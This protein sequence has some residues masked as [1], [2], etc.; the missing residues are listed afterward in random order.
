MVGLHRIIKTLCVVFITLSVGCT[1][2]GEEELSTAPNCRVPQYISASFEA[3]IVKTNVANDKQIL[4]SEGDEIAYFPLSNTNLRY[5]LQSSEGGSN[6]TFELASDASL[7]GEK[8]NNSYAVYPYSEAVSITA[9]GRLD[10][11]LPEV[12]RYAENSF[13][14]GA[15]TMVA[16]R[17]HEEA[18]LRFRSAVG[19][20]KLQLYGEAVT[21]K[22]IELRGNSGEKIAGRATISVAKDS[23]PS[24]T[25]GEA[26]TDIVTLD[27]GDGVRISSDAAAPTAFWFTLPEVIF[28][29]G[30][31]ITIYDSEGKPY[32]KGTADAY[33]IDRNVIQPMKA[34]NVRSDM[35]L[36]IEQK[37]GKVRFMLAERKSDITSSGI[38]AT[39][40]WSSS[41]V[42]LNGTEYAVALDENNRPYIDADYKE[43][44]IY[45]AALIY[46]TSRRWYGSTPYEK[47]ILPCS[48]FE[49]GTAQCI[50][51]QPMYGHYS[52]L[53]G[54]T[55]LFSHGFALL[56][57][58]IRG[59][60]DITSL[61]VEPKSER[62]DL[63][64]L[65]TCSANNGG[66][67]V[68]NGC[69]FVALNCTNEGSPATLSSSTYRDFYMMIAPNDYGEGLRLSICDSDHKAAF[70]TLSGVKLS[71]GKVCTFELDY[72]PKSSL[73][74]YEGF[75]NCVW[76]GDVVR[77]SEGA[78]FA[79]DNAEVSYN[80]PLDR[81]GYEES[82]TTVPYNR[83]GSAFVQ[84]NT[85]DN[86]TGKTVETSH[87]LTDSYI[88]S[89]HFHDTQYLFRTQE[90][91]GYIAVGTAT[92]S[93]GIYRSPKV[94]MQGIGSFKVKVRLAMQAGFNG[95]L[96]FQI[97]Y[98]GRITA[99][100]IDDKKIEITSANY[101]Y[102]GVTA[103]LV[104]DKSQLSIA[105]N[106]AE[107]KH[108]HTI[109]LDV[110][111]A[112]DGSQIHI[113]DTNVAT[114]VHGIYIDSVEAVQT[115]TWERKSTTLRVLL[116]NIQ[117]GMWADQHNNYDNFV[118]WVKRWN[119]DLCI[120]CESETIYKDKTNTTTSNKYL[121]DGWGELAKRY[122]H[123]YFAVGGNRDNFPQTV[124]SKYP[125][126]TLQRIT[127]TDDKN[128][129][130]SHG[131]GHF[132][133][134]VY[135]KRIN[136][137]TLHL[138]PQSYGYG[139]S[140]T[141][142]ETSTANSEGH[143][144]RI[145]EMQ[146][147]ADKTVNNSLYAAE[148]YWLFGGDTNARSRLDNWYYN[149]AEDALTLAAHDV[150]L[151]GTTLKDMIGHRYPGSFM[152]TNSANTSRIDIM[153][154]SPA[155]YNATDN[156]ITLIDSW[157]SRKAK[158]EYNSSFYSPSDHS[159]ILM[160]F[161]LSK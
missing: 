135:G 69:S 99:A 54:S 94:R 104:F 144:Q 152:A 32:S 12:Q 126:T 46:G 56:R 10:V 159:P 39:R 154:A 1:R 101:T 77:G 82:L 27:C 34:L 111:D 59:K 67:I 55:L 132:A 148:E 138:W 26:A 127:D 51:S 116:W 123:S 58:R 87:Q 146:Y 30:F 24:V 40:S 88:T 91:P 68:E 8:L 96:Q 102:T 89:R 28:S 63:S 136:I 158:S 117:N 64:G 6:G 2:H 121:P 48:Q 18:P 149:Y 47:V 129:P 106:V 62:Y 147:I 57:I 66:Y 160:D 114:G 124:T 11:V 38:W 113:T 141:D 150:I 78:G 16:I 140:T 60:G 143:K 20:L 70:Y 53:N 130:V 17:E 128:R 122:G 97:P 31:C 33:S 15:A 71:A 93:R 73:I 45:N 19:Y 75:D 7:T 100:K 118:E 21:I 35:N 112:A 98:G 41:R 142:R 13:G 61:R 109:E 153:Y 4:W 50:L 42:W 74:F 5:R 145:H 95:E 110:A 37:D 3:M 105:G 14:A 36:D 43:D 44:G 161:D 84:S 156:A 103:S 133:I 76:G 9:D 80:A 79:P 72:A 120:W 134:T 137:V 83:A 29:K 108:W 25:L 115:S 90:H 107:K 49:N 65:A 155:M 22:R 131:A 125:I 86:V 85:W 81:T 23:A 52:K 151:N 139:V 119:P 92:K 157:I